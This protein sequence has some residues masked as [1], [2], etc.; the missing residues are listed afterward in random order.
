MWTIAEGVIVG[1]IALFV[2]A[3]LADLSITLADRMLWSFFRRLPGKVTAVQASGRVSELLA[4]P[5]GSAKH[6]S[7]S[8]F[9]NPANPHP[10]Q[11]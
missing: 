3:F 6:H 8:Q 1:G 4:G 5:E 9:L 7:A 10:Q 2:L 11:Q